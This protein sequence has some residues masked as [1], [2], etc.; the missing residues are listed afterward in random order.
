MKTFWLPTKWVLRALSV[1]GNLGDNLGFDIIEALVPDAGD[2]Y[3]PPRGVMRTSI[4]SMRPSRRS[5]SGRATPGGTVPPATTEDG[6]YAGE[7][8]KVVIPLAEGGGTDTWARFIGSEM[9]HF[10]PGE[11]GF[12]PVNESGGE[13]ISG[14]NRFA[15]SA[16]DNAGPPGTPSS[17]SAADP[18]HGR[19]GS[20]QPPPQSTPI[21]AA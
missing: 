21:P 20:S 19:T 4:R 11:P 17:G 10:I 15:T 5:T 14:S 2:F 18:N 13:G 8:L 6:D 3:A 12:A 1:F 16:R 9:T 7:T